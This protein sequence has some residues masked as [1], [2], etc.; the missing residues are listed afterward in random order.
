MVFE[1]RHSLQEQPAYR[2]AEVA[3][4]LALPYGTVMAWSFGQDY[5][6][7]RDGLRKRF[8]ALVEPDLLALQVGGVAQPAS[9]RTTLP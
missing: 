6:R 2:G 7:R 4:I 5:K 3:H 9:S 8:V 1:T